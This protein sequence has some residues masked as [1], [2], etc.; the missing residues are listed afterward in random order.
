ML[1]SAPN[2]LVKHVKNEILFW[3]LYIQYIES[4]KIYL[5]QYLFYILFLFLLCLTNASD[6]LF[7]MTFILL[8]YAPKSRVS[9]AQLVEYYII[10]TEGRSLNPVILII[11]LKGWNF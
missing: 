10:Y 9:L 1:N 5:Y 7:N 3:N 4:V 11:H 6:A 2:A 8:E